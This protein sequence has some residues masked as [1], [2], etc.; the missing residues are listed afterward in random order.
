MGKIHC[1]D[2]GGEEEFT[3][4]V[5]VLN[6]HSHIRCDCLGLAVPSSRRHCIRLF[7]EDHIRGDSG[8]VH[9]YTH[10]IVEVP[11]FVSRLLKTTKLVLLAKLDK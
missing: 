1:C 2:W 7:C 4:L 9:R 8:R 6:A 5:K 11:L 10:Y 3:G